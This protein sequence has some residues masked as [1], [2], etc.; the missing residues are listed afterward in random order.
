MEKGCCKYE[1][2]RIEKIAEIYSNSYRDLYEEAKKNV[3]RIEY[4]IG[5]ELLH[6]GYY[7][8]SIIFDIVVGNVK[9]GRSVKKIPKKKPEFVFG[10]DI[11]GQILTVKREFEKEFIITDG[12]RELGITF[13]EIGGVSCISECIYDSVG[14][15]KSYGKYLYHSFDKKVASFYKEEYEYEEDKMIVDWY[16]FSDGKKDS[17]VLVRERY[18]FDVK[19]T[20]LKNYRVGCADKEVTELKEEMGCSYNVS[21]KRSLSPRK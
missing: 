16:Q 14:R 15:I 12:L 7:C 2:E 3:V 8:P 21:V 11:E 6:R 9:R 13:G 1:C 10:F 4:G 19:N 5:G 18:I 20:Y 17:S